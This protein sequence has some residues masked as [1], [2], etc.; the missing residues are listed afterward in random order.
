MAAAGLWRA[1]TF[2][3]LMVLTMTDMS[4]IPALYVVALLV[5]A[6]DATY[7]GAARAVVPQVVDASRLDRANSRLHAAEMAA[8]PG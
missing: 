2:T 3:G 4:T 7:E 5:G 8:T 1:A 6:A